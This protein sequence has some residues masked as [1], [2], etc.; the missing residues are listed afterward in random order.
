MVVVG[1]EEVVG[2][3]ELGFDERQLVDRRGD[4]EARCVGGQ[5]LLPQGVGGDLRLQLSVMVLQ[6]GAAQDESAVA[7]GRL[8]H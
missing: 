3:G 8:L 5:Q 7:S 4:A 2:L 6:L 1:A